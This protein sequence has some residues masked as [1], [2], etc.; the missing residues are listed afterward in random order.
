MSHVP[1]PA[2]PV[3]TVAYAQGFPTDERLREALR[4]C[5]PDTIEAAL[6]YRNSGDLA[7]VPVV[8]FGIIERFVESG[9][10]ARLTAGGDVRLVEDL[11]LDSLTLMEIILL[12]EEVLQV[13]IENEELRRLKTVADVQTYVEAK[14]RGAPVATVTG[15]PETRFEWTAASRP[16][17]AP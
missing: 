2:T 1:Q 9:L 12:T 7:H 5:S 14:L 13:S 3:Q 16:E 8:V 10:R 6:A 15:A 17:P 11:S 4:R